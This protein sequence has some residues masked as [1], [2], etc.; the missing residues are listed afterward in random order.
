MIIIIIII[1]KKD[2]EEETYVNFLLA[3]SV[4]CFQIPDPMRDNISCA[5]VQVVLN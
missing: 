1:I 2:N 5:D 4:Q 3:A